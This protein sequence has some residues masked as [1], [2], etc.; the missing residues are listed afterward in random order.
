MIESIPKVEVWEEK[1][2]IKLKQSKDDECDCKDSSGVQ[3]QVRLPNK[4]EGLVPQERDIKVVNIR[5]S[6]ERIRKECREERLCEQQG[7]NDVLNNMRH[8]EH[9]EEPVAVNIKAVEPLDAAR[10]RGGGGWPLAVTVV[11]PLLS[12]DVLEGVHGER[13]VGE[14]VRGENVSGDEPADGGDDEADEE[15]VDKD[16]PRDEL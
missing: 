1:T 10:G 16:G 3:E 14:G 6:I 15:V 7:G 5:R 13:G 9:G 4:R 12:A 2:R 8:D 11:V